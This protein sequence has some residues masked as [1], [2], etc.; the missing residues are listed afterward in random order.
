MQNDS[1]KGML[2][3]RFENFNAAPSAGLWDAISS[4]LD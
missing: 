3:S 2:G 1:Q 4:G